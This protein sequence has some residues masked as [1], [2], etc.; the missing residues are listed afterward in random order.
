MGWSP[1][2]QLV[3]VGARDLQKVNGGSTAALQKRQ[4]KRKKE[5][6]K[7]GRKE[8]RKERKTEKKKEKE[9]ETKKKEGKKETE[10]SNMRVSERGGGRK[11]PFHDAQRRIQ[12]MC[13]EGKSGKRPAR[14]PWS[15]S[16]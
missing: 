1:R 13:T 6:R 12:H 11:H 14:L 4:R 9:K 10:T 15:R 16:S 7:E 5:R 2:G 8:G 3:R